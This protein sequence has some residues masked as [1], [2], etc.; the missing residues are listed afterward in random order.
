MPGK[1]NPIVTFRMPPDLGPFVARV[2]ERSQ[3]GRGK[4]LDQTGVI[5][6]ALREMKAHRQR[7]NRPRRRQPP[8]DPACWI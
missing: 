7:S 8:V 5:L 1:G 4:P 2:I 6:R 3:D